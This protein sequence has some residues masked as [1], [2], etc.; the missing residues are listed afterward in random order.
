MEVFTKPL[1]CGRCLI[2]MG[3][4]AGMRWVN[5]RPVLT[6]AG[7]V[8]VY[9]FII[10]IPPPVPS[11]LGSQSIV[12]GDGCL[13]GFINGFSPSLTGKENGSPENVSD[14]LKIAQLARG[15]LRSCRHRIL[16]SDQARPK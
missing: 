11:L 7:V 14:L 6:H 10:F 2:N 13:P 16:T 3:G 1:R 4:T 15:R 9:Q 12:L 8:S 5:G